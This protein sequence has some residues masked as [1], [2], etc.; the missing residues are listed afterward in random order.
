MKKILLLIVG[1]LTVT[2]LNLSAKGDKKGEAQI[3]FSEN[4][5]NFGIIHEKDG[6]VTCEFEFINKG[7]QNLVILDATAQC[8][9]TRPQYPKKP[10]APG[11]KGKIKVTY[12]PAGVRGS[13]DKRITVK[14]NGKPSKTYLKVKGN[15]TPK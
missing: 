12:N 11:K 7:D 13:F 10:I 8:G 3:A 6:P 4:A 9:C 5:H 1:L 2:S 15:V 14:S